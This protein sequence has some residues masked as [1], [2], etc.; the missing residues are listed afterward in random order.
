MALLPQS[1]RLR[2]RRSPG[3]DGSCPQ[4]EQG[5]NGPQEEAP[6]DPSVGCLACCTRKAL[7]RGPPSWIAGVAAKEAPIPGVQARM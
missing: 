1:P 5:S 7:A 2:G 6:H 3:G 4:R